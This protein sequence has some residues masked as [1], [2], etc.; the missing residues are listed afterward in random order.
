VATHPSDPAVALAV[1]DAIVEV[2]GA[3]GA[4][5][6]PIGDFLLTQEEAAAQ[7]GKRATNVAALENRLE[8][9][10]IITGFRVPADA[11]ARLSAYVKVRERQSYEYAMVSAAVTI[12]LD[13]ERIRSARL[14]L[15]S[16]AQ[17]PWRL[18]SAERAL[19][20]MPLRSERVGQALEL[21]LA[22]ARPPKG[23][24]FKVRLARNA[25]YR[26]LLAAAGAA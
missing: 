10:E 1:L 16:V 18:A 4:R 24:E 8:A 12:D 23:N 26:A 15:G 13:G 9:G 6:T 20:G 21:A 17:K 25:A 7:E 14:A 3:S 2:S 11:R 22:D 19:A 5:T